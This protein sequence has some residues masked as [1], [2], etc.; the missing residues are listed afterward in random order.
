MVR[1]VLSCSRTIRLSAVLLIATLALGQWRS[2]AKN[3]SQDIDQPQTLKLGVPVEGEIAAMESLS[4]RIFLSAGDYLRLQVDV[5]R[6]D[7]ATELFAPGK[8]RQSGDK[9]LLSAAAGDALN[10]HETRVFSFI[11]EASGNYRLE[12]FASIQGEISE[13]SRVKAL[14]KELRPATPVDR[15]RIEAE[16]AE[17]EA[18]RMADSATL[19]QRRQ[20]IANCERALALWRE[21]GDRREELVM[22]QILGNQYSKLGE[23]QTALNYNS[24]AIQIAQ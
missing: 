21:L 24:R 3:H 18:T 15:N 1:P 4:W 6:D 9:P 16:R 11:A 14:I 5:K 8:S 23:L 20:L 19:K 17:L 12:V 2:S 13:R 7:L 22:L 10:F